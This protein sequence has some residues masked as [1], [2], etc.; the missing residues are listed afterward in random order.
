MK[1]NFN[2]NLN[3]V[4]TGDQINNL[5]R[6]KLELNND[7]VIDK[8]SGTTLY[9]CEFNSKTINR[10]KE[11]IIKDKKKVKKIIDKAQVG[12]KKLKVFLK[13]YD[14]ALKAFK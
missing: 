13:S 4:K 8:Q 2:I 9:D 10:I 11:P 7:L 5:L 3:L 14:I 6:I 1:G 12:G